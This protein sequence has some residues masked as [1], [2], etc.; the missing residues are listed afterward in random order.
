MSISDKK[1]I[2][3]V[4]SKIYRSLIKRQQSPYVEVTLKVMQVISRLSRDQLNSIAPMIL[5]TLLSRLNDQVPEVRKGVVF[6]LVEASL[7][8]GRGIEDYFTGLSESQ[9]K[10]I[11]LYV[12]KKKDVI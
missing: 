5:P 3:L 11:E 9:K 10:L 2:E 1:L 12:N 4:S 7:I 8:M 6:C